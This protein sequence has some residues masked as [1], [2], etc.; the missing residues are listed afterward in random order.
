MDVE[1]GTVTHTDY[2]FKM[3]NEGLK[4]RYING[5]RIKVQYDSEGEV[6]QLFAKDRLT[7]Q[8][9]TSIDSC[10]KYL[11]IRPGEINEIKPCVLFYDCPNELHG[12]IKSYFENISKNRA[13]NLYQLEL[14][15]KK[16][17]GELIGLHHN[18]FCIVVWNEPNNVDE[19]HQLI[20]RILRLNTWNNPIYF[21][22]TCKVME[23][24]VIQTDVKAIQKNDDIQEVINA[25]K[26]D[27]VETQKEREERIE[28]EAMS[29][30]YQAFSK[31][32]VEPVQDAVEDINETVEAVNE[33]PVQNTVE[34]TVQNT[35]EEHKQV[36]T[37]ESSSDEF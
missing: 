13:S 34:S 21:Y 16:N 31:N 18:I 37:E 14:I 33:E 4:P 36:V 28:N 1:I 24:N 35:V 22:I 32:I 30:V 11:E 15:F 23:S 10:L 7:M 29:K 25:T 19:I 5:R 6:L 20:G 26:T 17:M 3:F 2:Y 9:I 8:L 27:V 12:R